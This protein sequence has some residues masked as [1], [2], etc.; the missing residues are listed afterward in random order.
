VQLEALRRGVIFPTAGVYGNV[1]RFLV[2]LTIPDDALR[3]GLSVLGEAFAAATKGS[4]A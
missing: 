1:V 2:P 3:E 4:S